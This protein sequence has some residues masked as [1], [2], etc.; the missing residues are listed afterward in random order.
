[1]DYQKLF[2]AEIDRGAIAAWRAQ[3]KK[4]V[5]IVCGHVPFEIIHAAGAL[6]VR[7][8]ATGCSEYSEAESWMSSFGCS[9]A[10]SVLQLLIDGVYE[11][12]GLVATDG[13]ML[14]ARIYDNW[15]YICEKNGSG[16]M[17]YE[18]GAPRK[19]SEVTKEFYKEELQDLVERMEKLTGNRIT[20]E[21]L[22]KSVDT[23]NEARRLLRQVEALQKQNPPS[24]TGAQ[25]MAL[26]LSSGN[27]PIE[28][29]IELLKAF[30]ADAGNLPGVDGSP[31]RL[32][33]IGSALDNPEYIKIIES[34]GCVVV[35]DTLCLGSMMF[36]DEFSLREGQVLKSIADYYLERLVCPRM[37]DNR[38]AL[39]EFILSMAR[40]YSVDGLI[41]EKMQNCECWGGENFYLEPA[42]KER[43][44]PILNVEREQK[45]QSAGQLGIRVEA[46]IEMMEK[47]D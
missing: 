44:I 43:G 41:Y 7:L 26:H 20:E 24:L 40:E 21:A 38:D 13:C 34:K 39:H 28:E 11:L 18:L 15:K 47:E 25:M 4:A 33:L 16:Q 14:A 30:L 2:Q 42:L 9:Y 12:D 45:V 23:Y 31:A 46:F 6:P 36:G 29:Y 19:V 35:A 22:K 27:M 3:G 1:M 10:K 37:V 32:L 17:V 5:G 8:R